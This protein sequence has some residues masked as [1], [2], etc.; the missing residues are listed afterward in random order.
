MAA[1]Q[2][3][4]EPPRLTWAD[5]Q[6]PSVE[7]ATARG[8]WG[9]PIAQAA[10]ATPPQNWSSLQQPYEDPSM[11]PE[12]SFGHAIQNF[13]GH[14]WFDRQSADNLLGFSPYDAPVYQAARGEGSTRGDRGRT[15]SDA[16]MQAVADSMGITGD[17]AHRFGDSSTGNFITNSEGSGGGGSGSGSI[18]TAGTSSGRSVSGP[19]ISP[20][21]ATYSSGPGGGTQSGGAGIP[22]STLSPSGA[23]YTNPNAGFDNRGNYPVNSGDYGDSDYSGY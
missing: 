22:W 21:I 11:Y 5:L 14:K 4:G 12:G 23:V 7:E 15:S 6:D 8:G 3:S 1:V 20:G 18:N 2:T 16:A 9:P 10:R 17:T 13:G 19:G